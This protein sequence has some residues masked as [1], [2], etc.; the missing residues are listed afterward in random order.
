[1]GL[2]DFER[3]LAA[4]T[5]SAASKQ[6]TH[7]GRNRSR[8]RSRSRSRERRHRHKHHSSRPHDVGHRDRHRERRKVDE[9]SKH[10][11]K[12]RRHSDDDEE[13]ET[14]SHSKKGKAQVDG[15]DEWIEKDINLPAEDDLDD[16]VEAV[17]DNRVQRDSWMQAP[18][19]LDIDY[20]QRKKK[21]VQPKHVGQ[22]QKDYELK[23]HQNEL[24]HLL[25]D[26]RE[27]DEMPDDSADPADP[28]LA[29]REV[30]YT[31]GDRGSKWRMIKLKG[32]YADA[33]KSGRS[34]DDIALERFGDL[35]DFDDAREE[36][37]ELERRNTYGKGYIGKEKPNGDL[38]IERTHGRS[39]HKSPIAQAPKPESRRPEPELSTQVEEPVSFDQTSLNKLKAR[40]MK[41]KLKG[42]PEA[43]T[44]QAQ[45]DRA[46][47]QANRREPEV[48]TLNA[49][50]NRM[51]VGGRKGEVL[52]L[53][54]K[55]GRERGLVEE[56]EDMSIEDMVRQERRNRGRGEGLALAE[57][58]AKD[59]KFDVS[60]KNPFAPL[61]PC[62]YSC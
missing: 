2:E 18:S 27:D 47:Q 10:R 5:A 55:R 54:N 34:V 49:M 4:S 11:H 46:L 24:N 26:L 48:V 39:N 12:R 51:L 22:T 60:P 33:K 59:G 50:E 38:F 52:K 37:L 1:M 43:A 25:K 40:M 15:N 61:S 14:R 6:D 8:S 62:L 44:L 7:K 36:E 20:V 56:N 35:R 32:V 19:A 57:R 45:Y 53:D 30:S 31:I 23:I 41:A 28:E 9:D 3:E 29:K 13:N 42:G 21:E 16:Q 58:I 17:V